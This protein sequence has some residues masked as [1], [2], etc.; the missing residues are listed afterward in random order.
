[1]TFTTSQPDT[2]RSVADTL[3]DS[4]TG[5]AYASTTFDY[6]LQSPWGTVRDIGTLTT[7]ANGNFTLSNLTAS[8]GTARLIIKDQVTGL[9]VG[10][11][12]VTVTEA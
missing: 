5:Q 12:D 3:V 6:Q 11:A 7:D 10:Q 9:E 1:M 2:T 8:A 4:V